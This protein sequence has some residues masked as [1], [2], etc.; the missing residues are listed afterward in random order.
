[1]LRGLP[2]VWTPK[3]RVLVLG[4]LPGVRSL[5]EARYY[6]HPTN[7]FWRLL[8]GAIGI[9]LA[10]LD[11]PARLT[12]LGGAGVA[13]WDAVAAGRRSGSL[14]S[15]LR[16]TE[17]SDLAALVA[18]LP[19]LRLIACNGQAAAR[20]ALLPPDCGA[21]DLLVLP[22]SSA[23]HTVPLAVK[24]RAWDQIGHHLAEPRNVASGAPA[25]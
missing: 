6:A 10:S 2:P 15:A 21:I 16:V 17:R 9:D 18:Q 13:L 8:G 1:M 14:D 22:S 7:Q 24:Q 4:S 20:H 3:A 11:Y 25:P 19:H 5:E 23:A 12:A